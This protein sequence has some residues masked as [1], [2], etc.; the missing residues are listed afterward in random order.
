[1]ANGSMPRI[2]TG[3]STVYTRG[4]IVCSASPLAASAGI[5]VLNAGGNAFDAAVATAAVETVTIP[6]SCGIGGEPFVLLYEA[7]TGKVHGLSGSG[8]APLGVDRD[9]FVSRGHSIMPQTGPHAAAIPGEAGAYQEIIERFGTMSLA[10]LLEPA[11]GYAEEGYPI[12]TR[13]SGAFRNLFDKLKLYKD[14]ADIFTNGDKPFNEG[15]IFANKNLAN[16]LRRIGQN[17]SDEM[18]KGDTAR[19]MVRAFQA[20]GGV[21]TLEEFADH[22]T[23]W[24]EPPISTTYRGHTVFE[25]APPSHGLMLLEMLNIMDGFDVADLGFYTSDLVHMMVE[26]KKLAYADRNAYMGD[27]AFVD[28]PLEELISKSFAD[29]RRQLFDNNTTLTEAVAGPLSAP[30]P[31]DDNTSYFCVIDAEGNAASFIHSLSNGFGSGFV[32]GNTGV[33]LNNRIGRGFSL[34]E[35]HPNVIEPGK[36]TMHTLNAYMVMKE[37]KPFMVSGTPGGDSQIMWNAQ[38]ITNVVDFGMN[39][40]Q[41][42]EAPRWNN[43]PGTD[44][45][46]IDNP[47][48]LELEAGMTDEHVDSLKARG[49]NVVMRNPDTYG[50]AVQ[51]IVVDSETGVR[52]AG[53]DSRTDGHAAAL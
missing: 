40:Q 21:Y 16:T 45:A 30:V 5:G 9:F 26:A 52:S 1:M 12:P 39:A 32:A 35:G 14:T 27:L 37:G 31:G 49:H 42:V 8:K 23:E 53:S 44:P 46:T 41:A 25:T 15:E 28:S 51:L 29:Q 3:R 43:S 19:E 22:K 34:V 2:R 7:K 50:G 10:K 38:V 20:A 36:R 13:L 24:Y 6:A 4:G 11:I 17:G 47:F 48:T 33:I 18:Y